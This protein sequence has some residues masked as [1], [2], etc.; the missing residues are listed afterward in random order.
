MATNLVRGFSDTCLYLAGGAVTSGVPYW[1]GQRLLILKASGVSGDYIPAFRRGEFRLTRLTGG[2]TGWT[3]G[4]MLFW[5]A[6][7]VRL[8]KT[9]T[10]DTKP[11][12]IASDTV[13]DA[14][15]TGVVDLNQKGVSAIATDAATII[16]TAKL[17]GT[18]HNA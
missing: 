5:D 10:A 6:A 1:Q 8:T 14:T 17:A 3:I 16:S 7:N 11:A 12:G 13:A 15:T 18:M 2:G 9:P 4:A